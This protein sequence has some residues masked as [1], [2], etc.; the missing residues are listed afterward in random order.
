MI[1]PSF[2]GKEFINFLFRRHFSSRKRDLLLI[3]R[4]INF[5][6]R[7]K[8]SFQNSFPHIYFLSI[9]K[10]RDISTIKLT[11]VGHLRCRETNRGILH[12]FPLLKKI[13]RVYWKV[14]NLLKE[15]L[16]FGGMI[17]LIALFLE[18]TSLLDYFVSN[19]ILKAINMGIIAGMWQ[20]LF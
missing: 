13:L 9:F 3:T 4:S 17:F 8:V 1:S 16:V 6:H 15:K 12:T 20:V 11:F 19:I 18:S 14:G 5:L 2:L 10:M 7:R